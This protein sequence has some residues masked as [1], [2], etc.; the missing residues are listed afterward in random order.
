MACTKTVK[1]DRVIIQNEGGAEL[2]LL[3]DTPVIEQDGFAF[4]DLAHTGELLPAST[5][6]L[7]SVVAEPLSLV[8]LI[9][10]GSPEK[11]VTRSIYHSPFFALLIKQDS[12]G[13][14]EKLQSTICPIGNAS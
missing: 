9:V 2:G 1:K 5:I 7:Q 14:L 6:T 13:W 3:P 8:K 4:K 11:L 12:E 10:P